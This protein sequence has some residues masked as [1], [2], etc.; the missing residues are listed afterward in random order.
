MNLKSTTHK[1]GDRVTCPYCNSVQVK[2][3]A[4]Q[5]K[6]YPYPNMY[7]FS[8]KREVEALRAIRANGYDCKKCGNEFIS[9]PWEIKKSWEQDSPLQPTNL[10]HTE[11]PLKKK[12]F[13]RTLFSFI[14]KSV[15]IIV[16]AIIIVSIYIAYDQ[17]LWNN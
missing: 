8:N 11:K 10:S 3:M 16:A 13:F 7:W 4:N 9:I 6:K 14:F 5:P 1:D 15:L 12:G 17:N 2:S